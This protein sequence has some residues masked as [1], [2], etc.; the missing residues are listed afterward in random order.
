[1]NYKNASKVRIITYD[2]KISTLFCE[3]SMCWFSQQF[4]GKK[5]VFIYKKIF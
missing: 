1:M 4:S 5:I 2:W 3:V